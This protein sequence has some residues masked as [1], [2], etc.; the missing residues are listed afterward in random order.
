MH[1]TYKFGFRAQT[2]ADRWSPYLRRRPLAGAENPIHGGAF[3]TFSCCQQ[4]TEPRP[5]ESGFNI[6]R[7]ELELVPLCRY[8]RQ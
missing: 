1:F 8:V 3:K 5:P 2:Q 4:L 7:D 6:Q